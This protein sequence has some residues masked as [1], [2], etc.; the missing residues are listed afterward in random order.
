MKK[1]M[2]IVVGY[3]GSVYCDAALEDLRFAGLPPAGQAVVVS[4]ADDPPMPVLPTLEMVERAMLSRTSPVVGLARDEERQAADLALAGAE[5]LRRWLPLWDVSSK[6]TSGTPAQE[7]MAEAHSINAD[8]IVVGSQGR[9]AIGRF[10]L[11]SVSK[12]VAS[13]AHCSVRV[14]RSKTTTNKELTVLAGLDGSVGSAKAVKTLGSRHWPDDTL[15][16]VVVVDDGSGPR[17]IIDIPPTLEALITACSSLAPVE[18]R[19]MAEAARVLLENCG[20]RVEIEVLQEDPL[21]GLLQQVRKW[22]PEFVIVGARGRDG[23]DVQD[24]LGAVSSGLVTD[25]SCSVE[26]AR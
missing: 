1:Q 25:A 8:L 3:D 10:I 18:P 7:L 16:R 13:E 2:K 21:L 9:S 20:L 6:S 19:L 12:T 4:V 23:G 17:E 26:V 14:G 15:I 5:L 11:G 24:G 22:S